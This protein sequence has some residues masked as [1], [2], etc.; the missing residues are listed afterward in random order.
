[1]LRPAEA[2]VE[3]RLGS[4]GRIRPVR[5]SFSLPFIRVLQTLPVAAKVRKSR[6]PAIGSGRGLSVAPPLINNIK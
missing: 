4:A 5:G 2:A 3:S 6:R 1:M